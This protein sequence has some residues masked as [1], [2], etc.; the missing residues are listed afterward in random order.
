MRKKEKRKI[1][2]ELSFV[3]AA[4]MFIGLLSLIVT[5][6]SITGR[7]VVSVSKIDPSNTTGIL[8][9]LL[10]AVVIVA[11]ILFLGAKLMESRV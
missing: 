4:V 8:T 11:A 1:L 3:S 10:V 2:R 9:S 7:T 5:G 6:P